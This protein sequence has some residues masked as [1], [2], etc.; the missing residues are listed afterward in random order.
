[1]KRGTL[2]VLGFFGVIVIVVVGMFL[3]GTGVYNKLVGFDEGVQS[4]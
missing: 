2:I 3:W 4:A 1:M